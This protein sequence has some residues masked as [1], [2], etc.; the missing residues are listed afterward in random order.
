MFY[1][2]SRKTIK[3]TTHGKH[4]LCF[5]LLFLTG[6]DK[7]YT[8]SKPI[9]KP[10]SFSDFQ[11][12]PGHKLPYD[13]YMPSQLNNWTHDVNFKFEYDDKQQIYWLKNIELKDFPYQRSSI[14]F[15][16]SNFGWH[17]QFGF[18]QMRINSDDSIYSTP[19]EK[20]IVLKLIHSHNSSNLTLEL[21]Q[22]SPAVY[23]S[24]AVKITDDRLKPGAPL[25]T[26]LSAA[27]IE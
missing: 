10:L 26:E 18:G 19:P 21:P 8:L 24:F 11:Q 7:V 25:Y 5:L 9:N 13:L 22:N 14:E 17:Q 20:G 6:C 3:Y 2:F 16:I 1:S 4:L 27:P 12:L 15:K 23:V